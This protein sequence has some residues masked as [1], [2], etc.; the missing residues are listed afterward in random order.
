MTTPARQL[1]IEDIEELG[2]ESS[3]ASTLYVFRRWPIIPILIMAVLLICAI[4]APLVAPYDPVRNQLR[5]VLASPAWYPP[6]E[7]GQITNRF[8]S[9]NTNG[10]SLGRQGEEYTFLIGADQ[11]GRDLVS[12]IV[13]GARLSLTLTALSF[14]FIGDWLHDRWDPRLR[15][16]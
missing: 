10:I 12:R 5:A 11:L 1:S 8:Q 3:L 13:Y 4:F 15:Q 2:K 16:I 6:C 7:P 14:N 9:C